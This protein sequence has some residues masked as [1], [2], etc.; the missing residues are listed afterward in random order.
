[1]AGQEI[2]TKEQTTPENVQ[3]VIQKQIEQ[4]EILLFIKG[5]AYLPQCGFSAQIVEIFNRLGVDYY[6][7]NVLED[8]NIREGIKQ[9]S[10]WP[11]IPQ[12]YVKKEFLG[13]CDIV[14]ELYQSGEL[15]KTISAQ[16]E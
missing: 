12:V 13:G 16:A 6:T 5:T 1:M 14:T 2:E 9:Y 7:I 4:H 3:E 10:E 11:T 8:M 15:D